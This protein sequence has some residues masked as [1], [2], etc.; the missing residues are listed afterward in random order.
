M[1]RVP[2]HL[3]VIALLVL[4]GCAAQPTM[5]APPPDSAAAD[6]GAA[7]PSAE[8]NLRDGCVDSYDPATDYFPQKLSVEYAS[9]SMSSITATIRSS[10]SPIRGRAR[11]RVFATCSSSAARR[12]RQMPK[13]L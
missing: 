13:A 12:P 4:S 11:K 7:T 9:A 8:E 2:F 1:R 6:S 5:V 10:P 3:L